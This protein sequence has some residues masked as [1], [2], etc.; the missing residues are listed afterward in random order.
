MSDD[1]KARMEKLINLALK[2]PNEEEARS[3]ALKALRLINQHCVISMKGA[4]QPV[5]RRPVGSASQAAYVAQQDALRHQQQAYEQAMRN[6][7]SFRE[8][9]QRAKAEQAAEAKTVWQK[10][11]G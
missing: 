5:P 10:I 3:A 6:T 7:V 4:A 9:Y 11:W 2:N 1:I 8:H